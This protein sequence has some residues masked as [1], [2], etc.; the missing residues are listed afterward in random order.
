M[1]GPPSISVLETFK[2]L[3]DD[4]FRDA[5]LSLRQNKAAAILSEELHYL[6]AS[7]RR[8][9]VSAIR[10]VGLPDRIPGHLALE[11][12]AARVTRDKKKK[13]D[14]VHFVLLKKLGVPIVNGGIPEKMLKKTLE[15]LHT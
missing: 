5:P 13:G 3:V 10:A 15:G 14:T 12:I 7:D 11:E 2:A 8:R 4:A 1:K 9:I 6:P